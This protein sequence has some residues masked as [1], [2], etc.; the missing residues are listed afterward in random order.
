VRDIYK[1]EREGERESCSG[2]IGF[3]RSR[4]Y[5]TRGEAFALNSRS[6]FFDELGRRVL[7]AEYLIAP[8]RAIPELSRRQAAFPHTRLSKLDDCVSKKVKLSRDFQGNAGQADNKTVVRFFRGSTRYLALDA[9]RISDVATFDSESEIAARGKILDFGI[10]SRNSSLPAISG[11]C[12]FLILKTRIMCPAEH[13]RRTCE[14]ASRDSIKWTVRKLELFPI[15]RGEAKERERERERE[16][17]GRS[18]DFGGIRRDTS[19]DWPRTHLRIVFTTRQL[20]SERLFSTFANKRPACS[21]QSAKSFRQMEPLVEKIA[22]AIIKRYE[23]EV[24]P[25]RCPPL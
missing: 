15:S 11:R 12:A 21:V 19:V 7:S 10:F 6:A 24:Q 1:R 22:M 17:E 2:A 8:F 18:R 5:R 13:D 9:R 23:G 20:V 14:Q 4:M 25:R 3:P 16:R